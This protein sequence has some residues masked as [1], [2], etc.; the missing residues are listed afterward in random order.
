VLRLRSNELTLSELQFS[1][2]PRWS[3]EPRV[4]FATHNARIESVEEKPTWKS[5]FLKRHLAV[6]MSRFVEPIHEG[7]SYAGN[8][9]RF[10]DPEG[11]LLWAAGIYDTWCDRSTGELLESFAVL[12][13]AADPTLAAVGH[14]RSPVFLAP[15]TLADWLDEKTLS[16]EGWKELL[17]QNALETPVWKVEIDRPLKSHSKKAKAT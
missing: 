17:K 15:E 11:H 10:Q 4:K 14:D 13:R 16:A 8:M 9:V 5:S 12:T 7:S 2:L 3:K 1:L 6:P